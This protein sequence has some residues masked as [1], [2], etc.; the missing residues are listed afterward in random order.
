[1]FDVVEEE[2]KRPGQPTKYKPE[3]CQALIDFFDVEPWETEEIP[4]YKNGELA[5]MDKK[6]VYRR[7][8]SLL[9]FAKSI[10][11]CYRTVYDWA[12]SKHGSYQ[13]AFLQALTHARL[14]RKEMLIDL[15]LSGSVPPNSFKFVAVNMTDMRDKQEHELGGKDG[16][17]IPVSIV[18]FRNIK[19]DDN[20]KQPVS[21]PAG[22][23]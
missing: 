11:V 22:P 20:T 23:A 15:G 16:A 5:W 18:D 3:H 14:I 8:P 6:R 17:P 2:K 10:N 19:T 7:L 21:E 4:H 13:A 12:D 9:R 1:M